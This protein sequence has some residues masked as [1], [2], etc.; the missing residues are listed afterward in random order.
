MLHFTMIAYR[1]ERDDKLGPYRQRDDDPDLDNLQC[2]ME[3][4]HG[5][6]SGRRVW[7]FVP[8]FENVPRPRTAWLA[9]CDSLEA[10][11][12]W[13]EGFWDD[14]IAAGFKVVEYVT[15]EYI[16]AS[17]QLMFKPTQSE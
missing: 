13:F 4:M 2:R 7:D 17:N 15:E 9:G 12:E 3:L 8:E 10:L 5:F 14:L 6:G 11:K 16:C 1:L